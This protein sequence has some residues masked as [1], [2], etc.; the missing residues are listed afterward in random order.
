MELLYLTKENQTPDICNNVEWDTTSR[1]DGRHQTEKPRCCQESRCMPAHRASGC[2]EMWNSYPAALSVETPVIT[3]FQMGKRKVCCSE[4]LETSFTHVDENVNLAY[5]SPS[6][7]VREG[8][9]PTQGQDLR[10]DI[11]QDA[12][13]DPSILSDDETVSESSGK[14]IDYGFISAVMFLVT[15]ILLVIV[16]YIVPRDV[17][18]E[19]NSVPAREM[20]RLEKENARVGAHLDRCVIAGLCL[21]TLGG[22]VLSSLLMV[23]MWKGEIYRR[24]HFASSKESAKMYGSFSFRMKS[25]TPENTLELTL[26]EEDALAVET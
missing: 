6:L 9:S 19:P 10:Q 11:Q 21:L 5:R 12:A 4:E 17:K 22:V 8:Q 2:D 24:S 14:S 1:D 3:A 18:V 13:H 16:S 25:V 20:E 7:S 26:V 15:G 23:S